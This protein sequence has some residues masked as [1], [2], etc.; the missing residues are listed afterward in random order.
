MPPS[1][2]LVRV[3]SGT[4]FRVCV[5]YAFEDGY[6]SQLQCRKVY[7]ADVYG[8][9]TTVPVEGREKLKEGGKVEITLLS[10]TEVQVRLA[11]QPLVK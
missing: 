8:L 7:P 2:S 5:A 6:L 1:L 11:A 3:L 4:S 9:S 10:Y